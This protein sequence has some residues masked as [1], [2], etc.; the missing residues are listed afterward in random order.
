MR[1]ILVLFGV[2]FVG[3]FAI[4][5]AALLPEEP[6]V[7]GRALLSSV[8][9]LGDAPK[10]PDVPFDVLKML[11]SLPVEVRRALLREF[12]EDMVKEGK[13]NCNI[14]AG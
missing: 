11:V 12:G 7:D 1:N 6:R 8:R 2:A 14:L 3:V 13:A 9:R 10:L 4:P 5:T